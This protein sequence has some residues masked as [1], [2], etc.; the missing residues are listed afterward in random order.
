MKNVVII[1]DDRLLSSHLKLLL[2]RAGY[3]PHVAHHGPGAIKLIDEVAPEVIV[4]DMLLGGSTAMPLL[5]EL[6]SHEDLALIPIV[7]LTSLGSE[8]DE[9]SLK[10]YGVRE[11]LDKTKATPQDIVAAVGACLR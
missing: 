1:E 10:P 3:T 6:V 5:N 9:T 8:L 11:I 4:L 7:L 2:N